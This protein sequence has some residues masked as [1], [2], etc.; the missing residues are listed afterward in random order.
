L[1]RLYFTSYLSVIHI[2]IAAPKIGALQI[3][4]GTQSG[5]SLE[6]NTINLDYIL[7]VNGDCVPK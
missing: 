6:S 5:D 2:N 3:C 7:M 1:Y 4:P